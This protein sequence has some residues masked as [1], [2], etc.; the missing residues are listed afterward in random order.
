MTHL[1]LTNS[2]KKHI[3]LKSANRALRHTPTFKMRQLVQRM[4][5]ERTKYEQFEIDQKKTKMKDEQMDSME[6]MA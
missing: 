3:P 4:Q 5:R 1:D 2:D 6:I